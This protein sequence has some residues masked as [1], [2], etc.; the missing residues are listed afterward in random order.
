MFD[1]FKFAKNFLQNNPSV[2][3]TPNGKE[4]AEVIMN[5]D[6]KR[7]IEIANNILRAY[8]VTKEQ[9]LQRFAEMFGSNKVN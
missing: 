1:S 7:G 9:A 6:E 4:Y 5:N 3:N 2:Q 8:G